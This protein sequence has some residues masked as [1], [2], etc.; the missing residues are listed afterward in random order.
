MRLVLQMLQRV[1]QQT[2]QVRQHLKTYGSRTTGQRVG[3]GNGIVRHRTLRLFEPGL[4]F[5]IELER[6]VIGLIEVDVVQR[7]ADLQSINDLDVFIKIGLRNLSSRLNRLSSFNSFV[8]LQLQRF[9]HGSCFNCIR[10][11]GLELIQSLQWL[12]SNLWG[13]W[14]FNRC[15][16]NGNQRLSVRLTGAQCCFK[17][18]EVQLLHGFSKRFDLGRSISW[19][20]RSCR[21]W[22]EFHTHR[23]CRLQLRHIIQADLVHSDQVIWQRFRLRLKGYGLLIL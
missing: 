4:Q 8:S 11:F 3:I 6:S 2:S 16:S 20:R 13:Y 7:Q 1:L 12:C 18:R 15:F 23:P 5:L 22:C 21:H 19:R 9:K 17:G 14:G 10:F